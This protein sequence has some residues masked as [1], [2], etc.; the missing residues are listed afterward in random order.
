M[1]N[2]QMWTQQQQSLNTE[3]TNQICWYP[4]PTFCRKS[5][6]S[7]LIFLLLVDKCFL[8]WW[9]LE[10]LEMSKHLIKIRQTHTQ[11]R[12][13]DIPLTA[14]ILALAVGFG[15]KYSFVFVWISS[16]SSTVTS[17]FCNLKF[18]NQNCIIKFSLTEKSLL[19]KICVWRFFL[20]ISWGIRT[21]VFYK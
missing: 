5:A 2:H 17:V 4:R 14:I 12:A 1:L 13:L 18:Y 11:S 9:A 16:T 6:Y 21:K 8:D 10:L 15:C 20:G 7:R 19:I 3:R